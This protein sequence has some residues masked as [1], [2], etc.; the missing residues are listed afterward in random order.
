MKRIL[1]TGA[2][3][4][5]GTH[6]INS[7]L[8]HNISIIA[9]STRT[10][11]E[12]QKFEW[13]DKVTYIQYDI[14]EKQD[15]L[16]QLFGSPD[17]LIH[18]AWEGLPNYNE[19]FHINRNLP[20]NFSFIKT[21]IGEGLKKVSVLGTCAEY[22]MLEGCVDETMI[23]KPVSHYAVAKDR[24][25]IS[26]QELRHKFDFKFNWI[27]LF[28]VYG[29]GQNPNSLLSSLDRAL[30]NGESH[31][32]MSPGDQIRDFISIEEVT[33]IICNLSFLDE[34]YGIINCCTGN[35]MTVKDYV[36]NYLTEKG[37]KIRLNLGY[38]PYPHHEPFVFW[39]NRNKLDSIL[40]IKL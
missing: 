6:L 31:F 40:K 32:N 33:E 34:E 28:Y 37:K 19:D 30:E 8:S 29:K 12:I 23:T 26:L 11:S 21:L 7:L 17:E 2:T 27:R 39:G 35:A 3:G 10:S 24:L 22:G 16:M 18:S 36:E 9:S 38:Y 4:F 15:N 20:A 5:I 25:R 1:V 14:N 13:A